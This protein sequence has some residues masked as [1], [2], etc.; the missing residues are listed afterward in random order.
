M[1]KHRS[2]VGRIGTM[3]TMGNLVVS[4]SKDCN[5]LIWDARSR[6]VVNKW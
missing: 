2:H 5:V 6:E 3:D 4:G 1:A